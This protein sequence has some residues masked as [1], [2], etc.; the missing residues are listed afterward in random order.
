MESHIARFIH[1]SW[2]SLGKD[3]S[4]PP[5]FP[6]SQPISIERKH[7]P[8]L[9]RNSYLACEKTDGLRIALVCL[10]V[11]GA[12]CC[13]LVNRS[14]QVE[15]VKIKSLP[16]KAYKGTILDG[17]MVHN[18]EGKRVFMIY[19]AVIVSGEII[20]RNNLSMRLE[21]IRKFTKSVMKMKSDPFQI[22]LKTFYAMADMQTLVDRVK[23]DDFD[24]KN[25]GLIFTP[26]NEGVKMGTHE[27]CFK[28]KPKEM[29]TID[30]KV[31][32]RPD[33]SY[34]L[35]IQEKGEPIFSTLLK[36]DQVSAEWKQAMGDGVIVECKFLDQVWPNRWEPVL[37]RTD[38]NY[39]NSRRT[40]Q[41]TMVNIQEDIQIDEFVGLCK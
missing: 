41:R 36:P 29:N 22:K 37:I 9:S 2:G 14:L 10:E 38:K 32:H 19:D 34:G 6:G 1:G 12:R 15:F 40:Y 30:F 21:S 26:V 18:K 5:F 25:D 27:S 4:V 11:E 17:E 28:F 24:Y 3:G 23:S 39:P 31:K 8:T 16:G 20:K 7:F 13:A 33:G 35:F